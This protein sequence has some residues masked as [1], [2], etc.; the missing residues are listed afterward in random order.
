MVKLA[1]VLLI[2]LVQLLP[3]LE[4]N[5][6][7]SSPSS[8]CTYALK[9]KEFKVGDPG[10]HDRKWHQYVKKGAEIQA[11]Y[12]RVAVTTAS[13]E[14]LAKNPLKQQQQQEEQQHI[15]TAKNGLTF[16]LGLLVVRR[17]ER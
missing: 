15:A 17:M 2:A 8:F 6:R 13:G 5:E 3:R 14:L 10:A 9:P 12:R 1:M 4:H 11:T 16:V 7:A